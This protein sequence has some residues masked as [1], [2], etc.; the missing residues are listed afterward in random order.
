MKTL[1]A[2]AI[3][4]QA[5]VALASSGKIPKECEDAARALAEAQSING[6]EWWDYQHC[7][8]MATQKK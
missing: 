7:L 4:S 8:E 6:P 5:S 3:I 2:I 1:I